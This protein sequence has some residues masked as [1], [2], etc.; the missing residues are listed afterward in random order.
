MGDV[1]VINCSLFSPTPSLCA[2]VISEFGMRNDIQSYNLSGMGCGASLISVDLARSMLQNRTGNG[3][4]ALV[5]STEIISPNLYLGNEKGFL[6]QNMLFRCGGAAMVISNKWT[7]GRRA[8]Y[9]LLNIV[10]VQGT[11]E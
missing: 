4:R 6:L 9:K 2:M 10:R 7:D 11:K 5:I 3:G 8:A 1:L